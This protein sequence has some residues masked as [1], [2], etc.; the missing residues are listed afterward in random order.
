MMTAQETNPKVEVPKAPVPVPV[1]KVQVPVTNVPVPVTK[2]KPGH[3]LKV[4][5]EPP[6][7]E[8]VPKTTPPQIKPKVPAN[9]VSK[10]PVVPAN[11]TSKVPVVPAANSGSG[12]A[13][14]PVTINDVKEIIP[15]EIK[16][17]HSKIKEPEVKWAAMRCEFD[18]FQNIGEARP[19]ENLPPRENAKIIIQKSISDSKYR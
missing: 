7:E 4:N 5:K 18:P 1:P 13:T 16:V 2:V 3:F 9:P 8:Q 6:K 19:M 11:P 14:T 10:V 15:A 17:F 12:Q